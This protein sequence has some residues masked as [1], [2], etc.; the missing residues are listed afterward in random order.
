MTP[1]PARTLLSDLVSY[2][3][4]KPEVQAAS[5]AFLYSTVSGTHDLFLG[6]AHTGGLEAIKTMTL[7]IKNAYLPETPMFFASS[8]DDADTFALVQEQGLPFFSRQEDLLV[9]QELLQALLGP[10]E[11]G[12]PL[13]AALR[14]NPVY[15]MVN[16]AQL[17]EKKLA[18][19]AFAKGEETF[20]PL[21]TS[22]NMLLLG[23]MTALPPGL[24]LAPLTW[25]KHLAGTAPRPVVLNPDTP[26]A[27]ALD[28]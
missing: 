4:Q 24:V 28:L 25:G 14:E 23:G 12:T 6:V 2:F 20:T 5:F 8:E 21:F 11:D 13:R 10:G 19:Q 17:A 26:F 1:T 3:D 16:E 9:A 7:F 27:V 22:P 15:A 18:V